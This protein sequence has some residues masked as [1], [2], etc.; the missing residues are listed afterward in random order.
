MAT[1]E[2]PRLIRPGLWRDWAFEPA[3][4]WQTPEGQLLI[5]LAKRMEHDLDLCAT[6]I[7]IFGSTP[8]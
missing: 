7:G 6:S 8:L 4:N 3:P 1:T 5:N 2:L